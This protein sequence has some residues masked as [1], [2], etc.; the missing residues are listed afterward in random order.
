MRQKI[1]IVHLTSRSRQTAVAMLSVVFGVS[2]Y[3]FMNSFMTGV[4]QLQNDLAFSTL[5]HLRVYNDEPAEPRALLSGG[6]DNVV[7]RVRNAKK[8]VLTDGIRDSTATLRV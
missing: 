8:L 7:A 1:A 2:M 4:N 3:V 6:D 5:A